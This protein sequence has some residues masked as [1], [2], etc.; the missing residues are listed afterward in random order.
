[1]YLFAIVLHSPVSV[2]RRAGSKR[3]CY[4]YMPNRY[5]FFVN[6]FDFFLY[7]AKI[8]IKQIRVD[9]RHKPGTM[10]NNMLPSGPGSNS[11]KSLKNVSGNCHTHDISMYVSKVTGFLSCRKIQP[12]WQKEKSNSNTIALYY[13]HVS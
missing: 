9:P 1:M 10:L 13:N 8:V 12:V 4:S 2:A 11:K 3:F 7:L 6:G 5:S